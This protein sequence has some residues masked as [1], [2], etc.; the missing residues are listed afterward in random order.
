MSYEWQTADFPIHEGEQINWKHF[1]TLRRLIYLRMFPFA[2]VTDYGYATALTPATWDAWIDGFAFPAT[3][4]GPSYSSF[5]NVAYY[6]SVSMDAPDLFS[7]IGTSFSSSAQAKANPPIKDGELNAAYWCYAVDINRYTDFDR[8]SGRFICKRYTAGTGVTYFS[9]AAGWRYL[10]QQVGQ[11]H[12]RPTDKF[13]DTQREIPSRDF[14]ELNYRHISQPSSM[15]PNIEVKRILDGG[16]TK[17]QKGVVVNP[18]LLGYDYVWPMND[19]DPPQGGSSTAASD[20]LPHEGP[21]E[22]QHFVDRKLC[23]AYQ[24]AAEYVVSAGSW[25][26][27][28]RLDTPQGQE[29]KRNFEG[30]YNTPEDPFYPPIVYTGTHLQPSWASMGDKFWGCNRSPLELILWVQGKFDWYFCSELPY[31]AETTL[32]MWAQ[33]PTYY[34]TEEMRLLYPKPVGT[35]RRTWRH[36]LGRPKYAGCMMPG[37]K[38]PTMYTY[39]NYQDGAE[40]WWEGIFTPAEETPYEE[41]DYLEES[42]IAGLQERHD[43]TLVV[44]GRPLFER[45]MRSI[46]NDLWDV[47]NALKYTG[48]TADVFPQA[49]ISSGSKQCTYYNSGT[50]TYNYDCKTKDR[51][52]SARDEAIAGLSPSTYDYPGGGVINLGQYGNAAAS[53]PSDIIKTA[54]FVVMRGRIRITLDGA[55]VWPRGKEIFLHALCVPGFLSDTYEPIVSSIIEPCT[56]GIGG[57]ALSVPGFDVTYYRT[58]RPSTGVVDTP[59]EAFWYWGGDID[60]Y[61]LYVRGRQVMVPLNFDAMYQIAGDPPNTWYADFEIDG[62]PVDTVPDFNADAN[63]PRNRAIDT[64]SRANLSIQ[65]LDGQVI[66]SD[67]TLAVDASPMFTAKRYRLFTEIPIDSGRFNDNGFLLPD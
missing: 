6:D 15:G 49:K 47:L 31:I 26:W 5:F 14:C 67:V 7:V 62:Y 33:V 23:A 52:E 10:P 12:Q 21:A 4:E 8:Y 38:T 27:P 57:T 32:N 19:A 22:N 61:A 35:W 65:G 51:Y 34:T 36:T 29:Y 40:S 54:S 9:K 24:N 43:P 20:A 18:S 66:F 48:V 3:V 45:S 56:I 42:E 30:H 39:R 2:G 60:P 41:S 28:I 13:Q 50:D 46:L 11:E 1:E 25:V 44:G 55:V 63:S 53:V 16:T 64:M 37:E 59:P 58:P 17:W